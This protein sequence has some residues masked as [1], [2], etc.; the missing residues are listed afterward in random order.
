MN[1]N[2]SCFIVSTILLT[3]VFLL[4]SCQSPTRHNSEAPISNAPPID[5]SRKIGVAVHTGSRTCVQIAN[6]NLA[7]D[8]PIT[9]VVPSAPQTFT[10]AQIKAPSN[11]ACPI[12][13]D[14]NAS[15]SSYEISTPDDSSVPKLVPMIAVAGTTAPFAMQDSNV[16]ADLDQN[17]QHRTF[18]ECSANDGIY[19]TVWS[20]VPLASPLLWHRHYYE[21]GNPSLGPPCTPRETARP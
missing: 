18:R 16:T 4:A 6:S 14:L 17:G 9:L 12:T 7:P 21:A 8:S 15:A 2:R 1:L 19:L 3:L 5:Y 20:G 10:P 11:N 13:Q